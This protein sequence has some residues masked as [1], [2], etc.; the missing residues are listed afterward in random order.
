MRV[1]RKSWGRGVRD[2]R[3]FTGFFKWRSKF[4]LMRESSVKQ[5]KLACRCLDE[6]W[7]I[8]VWCDSWQELKRS[9]DDT[10]EVCNYPFNYSAITCAHR[11]GGGRSLALSATPFAFFFL[12]AALSLKCLFNQHDTCSKI[13]CGPLVT[14]LMAARVPAQLSAASARADSLQISYIS[15]TISPTRYAVR[16]LL[17]DHRLPPSDT[18]AAFRWPTR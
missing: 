6:G 15:Q 3:V 13:K 10:A 18:C 12:S 11:R 2:E 8:K 14:Q 5:R 9:R 4:M 17:E 7:C 1:L 16:C